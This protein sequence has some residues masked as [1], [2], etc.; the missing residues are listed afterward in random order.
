MPPFP[1][2]VTPAFAALTACTALAALLVIAFGA[3][4]WP[5]VTL[6]ADLLM[7]SETAFVE[8]IIKLNIG[9]PL[10]TPPADSNSIVYNPLAFLGTWAV[11]WTLGLT[12]SV[13]GLRA[14]QLAFTLLAALVATAC[15]RR[16]SAFAFPETAGRYRRTWFVFTALSMTLVATAPYA[17]QFAFALH[18][19]ALAQLMSILCFWA[20]LTY[21]RT[22]RRELLVALVVLPALA[23]M[24]KQSLALWWPLTALVVVAARPRQRGPAL[25]VAVGGGALIAL[26]VL[27]CYWVWGQP[28]WF[29]TNTVLKARSTIAL[30]PDAQS[31]SLSRAVDHLIRIWPDVAIGL[32]GAWLLVSR[33]AHA[34]AVGALAGAWLLLLLGEAYSSASGWGAL[35]HFG[36][37]VL[38]GATF[39]FAALPWVW[40]RGVDAPVN[41]ALERWGRPVVLSALVVAMLVVWNV[42]PTGNPEHPRYGRK[43]GR[44]ED[45]YRYIRDVEAE[46]AGLPAQ[47]VLLGVGS[48][49]YLRDGVLQ[50]DRAV[51][52]A[53]QPSGG[54]YENFAVTVGR[55]RQRAYDKILL[56]D[57]HTPFFMYD[58]GTWETSSGFRDAILEHYQ[59]VRTIAAPQDSPY[60][61]RD[62]L[63]A[64]DISVFVPRP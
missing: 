42:V 4:A 46:F 21:V 41:P 61:R 43:A 9:Q 19:D 33:G 10:Y 11:A 14:I 57:F 64:D 53:D 36:P 31:I 26:S 58:W 63:L 29:W 13:P 45:V 2:R 28:Y 51:S 8:N 1:L 22:E 48:W 38:I 24:V 47:K 44:P 52:L 30:S 27:I 7:F 37:G 62:I 5:L 50:K 23:F 3:F 54:I 55:I 15:A 34:R 18:V 6:P 32:A 35:Y 39:A 59:E 12:T 16:L 60:L 40:E 25:A 20:L 49:V 56:Q 17:N